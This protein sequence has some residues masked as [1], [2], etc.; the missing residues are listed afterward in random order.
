MGY[1]RTCAIAAGGAEG[2]ARDDEGPILQGSCGAG[3]GHH[4]DVQEIGGCASG[5]GIVCQDLGTT[6][7]KC[8]YNLF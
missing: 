8:K 7:I 5:V 6:C 3:L 2:A 1:P 4:V